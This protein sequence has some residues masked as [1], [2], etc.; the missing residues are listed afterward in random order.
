MDTKD[1]GNCTNISTNRRPLVNY[2][3]DSESTS[4]RI[5]E[6]NRQV[7]FLKFLFILVYFLGKVGHSRLLHGHSQKIDKINIY[8]KFKSIC[9]QILMFYLL[10]NFNLKKDI[11]KQQKKHLWKEQNSERFDLQQDS[12]R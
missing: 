1:Q 3:S 4:S 9:E 2:I 11:N 7:I 6:D 5:K 10:F 8:I 12:R